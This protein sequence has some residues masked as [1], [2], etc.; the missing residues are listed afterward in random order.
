MYY[1]GI[2]DIKGK[3]TKP[4]PPPNIIHKDDE[5]RKWYFIGTIGKL[6]N[7]FVMHDPDAETVDGFDCLGR[8]ACQ[9]AQDYTS[10]GNKELLESVSLPDEATME[11][12]YIP[13]NGVHMINLCVKLL[14]LKDTAAKG[15]GDS[16][17]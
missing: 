5:E 6:V 11:D 15:D 2:E 17:H 10:V 13:N 12:D 7:I 3:P 14:Q 1:Q 16:V 9:I 8:H 4:M